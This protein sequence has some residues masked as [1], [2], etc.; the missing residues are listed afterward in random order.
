MTTPTPDTGFPA[1]RRPAQIPRTPTPVPSPDAKV[2]TPR[3]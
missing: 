1:G 2:P 3:R